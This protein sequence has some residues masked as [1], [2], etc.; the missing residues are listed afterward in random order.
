MHGS[1]LQR[2]FVASQ[3]ELHVVS[4]KGVEHVPEPA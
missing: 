1:P 2:P 4:V 3:P